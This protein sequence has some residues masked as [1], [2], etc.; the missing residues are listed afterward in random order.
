MSIPEDWRC[1]FVLA[2]VTACCQCFND[3]SNPSWGSGVIRKGERG[4][5]T[6]SWSICVCISIGLEF[7]VVASVP[8]LVP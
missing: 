8:A 1:E 3:E 5:K 2:H 4:E 6:L 7:V